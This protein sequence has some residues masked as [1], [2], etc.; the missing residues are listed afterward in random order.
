[1]SD[2]ASSPFEPNYDEPGT[3]SVA[4]SF[5]F[6]PQAPRDEQHVGTKEPRRCRFC[7]NPPTS[8]SF[9]SDAHVVPEALGNRDLLSHEECD[10]CNNRGS[11]LETD[12]A[13]HLALTRA[14]SR[15]RGKR[16]GD[17]KHKYGKAPSYVEG[18]STSNT[19]TISK[20]ID[21]PSLVIQRTSTGIRYIAKIPG[22]RLVNVAKALGRMALFVADETD[23]PKLEHVRRWIRSEEVWLPV[24]MHEAFIPGTGLARVAIQL[25]R[26]ADDARSD[27]P[28]YRIALA[29]SSVVLFLHIP[30]SSWDL[31]KDLAVP[32][33]GVSPYPPH[34]VKWRK[35]TVLKDEVARSRVDTVDVAVPDIM[36]LPPLTHDQ[37]AEAA[38]S[39]WLKTGGEHGRHEENWLAAEQDLL[40]SQIG[41]ALG[42]PLPPA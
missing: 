27:I 39:R 7:Q 18:H 8:L 9:C 34:V 30:E 33:L 3:W 16:S 6:D 4:Y 28:P 26:R 17:I 13:S 40:W 42:W 15:I 29:Y 35:I 11:R 23:L 5:T 22:Y 1:M 24:V 25:Y 12:L 19:V 38:Y 31:P 36:K 32:Y 2:A 20:A 21:D 10:D 41:I 37:I 14:L